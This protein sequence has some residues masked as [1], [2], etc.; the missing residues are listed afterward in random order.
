MHSLKFKCRICK[1]NQNHKLIGDF[2]DRLPVGIVCVECLG[3]GVIGIEMLENRIMT[4]AERADA[5][6]QL[7]KEVH[8]RV[9]NGK[10]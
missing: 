5:D 2:N 10:L 4:K 6:A 7:L 8:E 1:S 3:C 9:L